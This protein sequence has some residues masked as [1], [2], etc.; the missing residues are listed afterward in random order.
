MIT[1]TKRALFLT[2]MYSAFGVAGL[3][4]SLIDHGIKYAFFFNAINGLFAISCFKRLKLNPFI[5]IGLFAIGV[6]ALIKLYAKFIPEDL[7]NMFLSLFAL[8]SNIVGLL[9]IFISRAT[10]ERSKTYFLL[11]LIIV[12]LSLIASAIFCNVSFLV[13]IVFSIVIGVAALSFVWYAGGAP[14]YESEKIYYQYETDDG[15]ILTHSHDNCYTDGCG[16]YYELSAD[17]QT[18][19]EL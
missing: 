2:A 10:L 4:C 6:I 16:G 13:G 3:V 1:N 11:N 15:R 9:V 12:P 8:L 5:K 19:S 14:K 17:G 18:M 7:D